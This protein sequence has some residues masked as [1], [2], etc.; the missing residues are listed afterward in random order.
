MFSPGPPPRYHSYRGFKRYSQSSTGPK[1]LTDGSGNFRLGMNIP[2]NR[3]AAPEPSSID[4]SELSAS[5]L[6][7]SRGETSLNLLQ[8]D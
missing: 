8:V 6:S 2:K 3:T 1:K 5:S 7:G 4:W